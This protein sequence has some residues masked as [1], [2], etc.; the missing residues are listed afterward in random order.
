MLV[1]DPVTAEQMYDLS[2]DL[3]SISTNKAYGRCSGTWQLMLPYRKWQRFGDEYV[4]YMDVLA[5]NQM[6]TVEMDAGDGAGM[7]PVMCGL[8]DRVSVV[9]QGG[10]VPQRMVKVSGR[11]FGKILETHDIAYDI[12]TFNEQIATQSQNGQSVPITNTLT[13]AFDPLV[14]TGTPKNLITKILEDCLLNVLEVADRVNFFPFVD[15][16]SKMYEPNMMNAQGVPLWQFIKRCE[17]HPFNVLTT[18]TNDKDVNAF[19]IILEAQPID[20]GTGNV[21]PQSGKW[22]TIGDAEIVSDDLGVSDQERINLVCYQPLMYQQSITNFQN[23][24]MVHP[25]FVEKDD[26][27]IKINGLHAHVVR[28]QFIPQDVKDPRN[29]DGTQ[30]KAWSKVLTKRLWAWYKNN[31]TYESGS[32]NIHLR[33][34][35]RVGSG[36]LIQQPDKT[37]REYFIEQVSHQCVFHPQPQFITTLQLTR[38]QKASPKNAE[39]AGPPQGGKS[40]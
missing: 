21:K 37:Y 5:P 24:S 8:I 19:D 28:D 32:A 3:T 12:L 36:L 33:P 7:F 31:H 35:I 13:R 4:G 15:D 38:G 10:P 16:T 39:N 2:D 25:D 22:H 17:H 23:I 14:I 29:S 34:D 30:G 9:R 26:A 1:K 20:G 18:D 6:L 11:D 40:A 27:S